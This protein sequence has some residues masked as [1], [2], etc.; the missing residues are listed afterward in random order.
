MDR[1]FHLTLVDSKFTTTVNHIEVPSWE[2]LIVFFRDH[3]YTTTDRDSPKWP[4]FVPARMKTTEE[5]AVLKENDR[6]IKNYSRSQQNLIHVECLVLDIDNTTAKPGQTQQPYLSIKTAKERLDGY[7][8]IFYTSF[9]HLNVD[10]GG[11]EKFRFVLPLAKTATL[12]E[13][14]ERVQAMKELFP[15]ADPAGFTVSQPFY[16]PTIHPDRAA[17][18]EFDWNDG[19]Y[20]DVHALQRTLKPINPVRE[21]VQS[22]EVYDDLPEFRLKNGATYRADDLYSWIGEYDKREQCFRLGDS[23]DTKPGCMV[24]KHYAGLMYYEPGQNGRFIKVFKAI[25][26]APIEEDTPLVIPWQRK[27]LPEV[28]K[29]QKSSNPME[30]LTFD[31]ATIIELNQRYLDNDLLK[32]VEDTGVIMVKS[33]KGTGKTTVLAPFV[34][35]CKKENKSVL[36]I[37]HR[38]NL[39]SELAQKLMLAYYLHLPA[40]EI[41]PHMA[42]C[43]DS[44]TRFNPLNDTAPHTI[45]IDES[46]QVFMHM[47]AATLKGKRTPVIS[48]FLWALRNAKR[49]ILLD[50]DMT[51]EMSLSLLLMIR[52][53]KKVQTEPYLALKNNY[54]FKDRTTVMYE[55]WHHLFSEAV[56]AVQAGGKVFI[57][58]NFKESGADLFSEIFKA[59]GKKVLLVSSE[60]TQTDQNAIDFM[61]DTTGES[62]KYDVIVCTPTVQTGVSIDN[63]HFTHVYGV[64]WN[65]ISTYQDIDQALSRVRRVDTHRVWVEFVNHKVEPETEQDIFNEIMGKEIEQKTLI[66]GEEVD[67]MSKGQWLWAYIYA[68]IKWLQGIWMFHKPVQFAE[69]RESLGYTMEWAN[70][71]KSHMLRGQDLIKLAKELPKEGLALKLW[72]LAELNNED[73][74]VLS[75]KRN[76]TPEEKLQV[77]R[78]RY[79]KQLDEKWSLENLEIAIKED[80]LKVTKKIDQGANW[81]EEGLRGYD[82]VSRQCN[83]ITTSDASTL[84]MDNGLIDLLCDGLG[85]S[86]RDLILQSKEVLANTRKEIVITKEQLKNM[87]AVF[88]ANQKSFKRYFRS[89]V[90]DPTN[91]KN[92]KKVWNSTI[93]LTL[94]LGSRKVGTKTERYQHYF[95]D[96]NSKPLTLDRVK[97]V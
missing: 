41:H 86:Y 59:L 76:A 18:F 1:N 88:E 67:R 40:G 58:T 66:Y 82:T 10:K 24:W 73:F 55:S 22:N 97:I 53:E 21:Y 2:Q 9:N 61:A 79:Q 4:L 60:T 17:N 44:M 95:V 28:V 64:F 81:D 20:F 63:D 25:A 62:T 38:V 5:G 7:H 94:P 65:R 15:E 78:K 31:D 11:V 45:I 74:E 47:A 14:K 70:T 35:R 34:Q 32:L 37:G 27:P 29:K 77:L 57:S 6:G 91:D 46:E 13:L 3:T 89:R 54:I 33:P 69:L 39:L 68:R 23:S 52:G 36:L 85:I 43:L 96:V 16:F 49:V 72:P 8:W 83:S 51:S 30:S 50:A 71:E 93:G 90:T 26:Q 48:A 12:D 87:A 75:A 92:L 84:L 42:I 80:L 19:V 56:D